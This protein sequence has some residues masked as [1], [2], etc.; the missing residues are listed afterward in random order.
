MSYAVV[1]TAVKLAFL[2]SN[3]NRFTCYI[4]IN[5]E[6]ISV[7]YKVACGNKNMLQYDQ[8]GK[9]FKYCVFNSVV[10]YAKNACSDREE[11]TKN[12]A[13]QFEQWFKVG[14]SACYTT[15]LLWW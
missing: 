11:V 2:L 5:A 14:Y 6:L 9:L 13:L 3:S 12:L 4:W 8:Q 15:V 7:S 10:H 1:Y